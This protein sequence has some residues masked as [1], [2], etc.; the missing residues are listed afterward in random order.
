MHE[1]E[2]V[3]FMDASDDSQDE[4]IVH[5]APP[6]R[7]SE[8]LGEHIGLNARQ[9]RRLILFNIP[10][11]LF[12]ALHLIAAKPGGRVAPDLHMVEYFSGVGV[13]QAAFKQNGKAAVPYDVKCDP[14]LNNLMTDMGLYEA[15]NLA[16][17][18]MPGG[19]AHWATVCSSWVFIC[20]ASTGRSVTSPLGFNT[21][22]VQHAN[23][24][25]ARMCMLLLLLSVRSVHWVLEQP[26]SSLMHLHPR[27]QAINKHSKYNE[28]NIWM[29]A[30]GAPTRKATVLRSPQQW[31]HGLKKRLPKD[32]RHFDSKE[33]STGYVNAAGKKCVDGGEGLKATQEYPKEYGESVYR[34]WNSYIEEPRSEQPE[35]DSDEENDLFQATPDMW[36]DAEL[37]SF[38]KWIGGH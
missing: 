33:V 24:M 4:A 9:A 36:E 32:K 28:V 25:V 3:V 18:L 2:S 6:R 38:A 20:Q 21:P 19:L 14:E 11:V 12:H 16:C 17:R 26:L 22:T 15:T 1:N 5:R 31:V 30:Y 34:C 8:A 35:T 13:V 7:L 29:G 37:N 27:M 10:P 23:A